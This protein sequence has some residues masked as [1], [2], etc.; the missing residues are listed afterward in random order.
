MW[1]SAV[2]RL[3]NRALSALPRAMA[4]RLMKDLPRLTHDGIEL[5]FVDSLRAH[6]AEHSF[7]RAVSAL[8]IAAD[9]AGAAYAGLKQDVRQIIFWECDTGLPY[10][11]YQQAIIVPPEVA[12]ESDLTCFAAWLLNASESLERGGRRERTAE[13]LQS[14]PTAE[15]ERV[16]QWL[17]DT[18]KRAQLARQTY[19]PKPK[20]DDMGETCDL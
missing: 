7:D 2:R 18:P 4:G 6:L 17:A 12:Q 14:L 16:A 5:T 10:H 8:Q 20:G 1:W 15:A 13:F 3:W 11:P 19:K 9:A